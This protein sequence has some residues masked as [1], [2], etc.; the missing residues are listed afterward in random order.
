M[1]KGFATSTRPSRASNH[2]PRPIHSE[3]QSHRRAD[4]TTLDRPPVAEHR[5]VGEHRRFVKR[6]RGDDAKHRTQ[7]QPDGSPAKGVKSGSRQDESI[8]L[9]DVGKSRSLK[10]ATEILLECAGRRRRRRRH[11]KGLLHPVIQSRP[12]LGGILPLLL[13]KLERIGDRQADHALALINPPDGVNASVSLARN[14]TSA[15]ARSAARSAPSGAGVVY[16]RV[17]QTRA[18]KIKQ[19]ITA[20]TVTEKLL[21]QAFLSDSQEELISGFLSVV[22]G[23]REVSA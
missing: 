14:S 20:A 5:A 4:S 11:V 3:W 17:F 6:E 12:G 18:A 15:L 7:S 21:P 23:R 1:R 22:P 8:L 13:R 10:Q 19:T 9:G 16:W 2:S